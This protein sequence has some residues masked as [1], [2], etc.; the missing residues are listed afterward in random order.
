MSALMIG[1]VAYTSELDPGVESNPGTDFNDWICSLHL[2]TRFKIRIQ[3]R[4]S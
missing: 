4:H 2:R 1:F 3:M